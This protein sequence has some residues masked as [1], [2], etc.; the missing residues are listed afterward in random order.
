MLIDRELQKL[1]QGLSGQKTVSFNYEGVPL[2]MSV[3]DNGSKFALS[4]LVY[5]GGNYIPRSV[6]NCI[7]ETVF[8]SPIKTNLKVDEEHYQIS[9]HYEGGAH[10]LND[11]RIHS[12]LEEFNSL[13][14]DWRLTLDEHD[15]NDLV[16]VRVK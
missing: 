4:A 3:L 13:V 11:S 7:R 1:F 2:T 8:P 10:H 6:R 14:A 5:E 9:L 15:K 16:H 12:L